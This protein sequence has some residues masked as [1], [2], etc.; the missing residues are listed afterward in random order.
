MEARN[1]D[2]WEMAMA[3]FRDEIKRAKAN[4]EVKGVNVL[5]KPVMRK[6]GAETGDWDRDE[7]FDL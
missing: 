4:G 7:D 2:I 1:E 3:T 6:G 5:V